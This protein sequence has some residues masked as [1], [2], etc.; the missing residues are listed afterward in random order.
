MFSHP[1]RNA[2]RAEISERIVVSICRT[3]KDRQV[4][5]QA[6]DVGVEHMEIGMS[7]PIHSD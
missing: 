2:A 7:A 3:G 4:K 6:W 5:G 1:P